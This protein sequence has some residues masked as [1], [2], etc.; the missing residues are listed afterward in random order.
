MN[1]LPSLNSCIKGTS[2][3]FDRAGALPVTGV[4]VGITRVIASVALGI[5]GIGAFIL[6]GNTEG[7]KISA[8]N[9][10]RGLAE[11][12]SGIPLIGQLFALTVSRYQ[13]DWC[14]VRALGY[15]IEGLS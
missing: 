6:F 2:D 14:F 3:T 12:F 10:Q 9:V 8:R 5:I 13:A 15:H 11:F 4:L 1:L 7:L